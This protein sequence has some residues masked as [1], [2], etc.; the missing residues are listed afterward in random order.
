[1]KLSIVIPARN[2]ERNIGRCIDEVQSV[3]RDKY[4]IAY[5]IV[6]VDDNSR[7]GTAEIVEAAGKD[8][9]AICLIRRS[10]PNGFGR[11]VKA[12]LDAATGDAVA[13]FMADLSD[14]AED[15]VAYYR[16]LEEGYDCVFGSRFIQGSYVERYP[17]VKRIINRIVNRT[18]QFLFWTQFNDLTNAFKAYRTYVVRECG[19]LRA[20]H[21]DLSLELA[22]SALIR[23]YRI[24]QVPIH[25][26]G[27]S[28]GWSNLNLLKMGRRYL[29]TLGSCL[30]QRYLVGDDVR[31]D[32]LAAA[33]ARGVRDESF[34]Q[35]RF[36]A[37]HNGKAHAESA[38]FEQSDGPAGSFDLQTTGVPQGAK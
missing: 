17:F 2:E 22:L 27:R 12:G 15:L 24:A 32:N 26:Y 4:N 37:E 34:A 28:F 7:D 13:V 35:P 5:E 36:G 21:F 25:W 10:L 29:N 3:V 14:S 16:K 9:P 31:A 18:I 11:A 1:M 38:A 6:V 19:T 20:A 8:D 30:L 23:K 33:N